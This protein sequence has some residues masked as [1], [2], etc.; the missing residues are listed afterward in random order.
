MCPSLV[1]PS[2]TVGFSVLV[3]ELVDDEVELEEHPPSASEAKTAA[4]P[5]KNPLLEICSELICV[6]PY[7][8][9]LKKRRS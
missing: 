5:P 1:V 3:L 8:L 2:L 7:L 9:N 4:L 6:P